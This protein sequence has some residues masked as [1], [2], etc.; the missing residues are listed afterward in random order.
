MAATAVV[1]LANNVFKLALVGRHAVR[2]VV[3]RFGIPAVV[4]AF[5]GAAALGLDRRPAVNRGLCLGGAPSAR[6][7]P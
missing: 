5:A 4:A 2:A 1:H 3:I 7:R 6:S